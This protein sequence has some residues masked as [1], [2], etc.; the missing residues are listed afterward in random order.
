MREK[1]KR[2]LGKTL[3]IIT[4]FIHFTHPLI[5]SRSLRIAL[6]TFNALTVSLTLDTHAWALPAQN[7]IEDLKTYKLDEQTYREV[8]ND[9][10]AREILSQST[11][12]A[13]GVVQRVA[14][15]T[16][17][18]TT[19]FQHYYNGLEVIGSMSLHHAGAQGTAI[20]NHL[21]A[22][23]LSTHPSLSI[24]EAIAIAQGEAEDLKLNALPK[25]MILP[26]NEERA[27][28]LIYWISLQ[29]TQAVG[30]K[31]LLI[32]AHSGQ[33]LAEIPHHL[34]LAPIQIYSAKNQG[35]KVVRN[36]SNLRLQ[37]KKSLKSCDLINLE[38]NEKK[39]ITPAACFALYQGASP[40]LKNQC[41]V[42]DGESGDIVHVDPQN[43][44]QIFRDGVPQTSIEDMDASAQRAAAHSRVVLQYYKSHFNRD[45]Y[46]GRGSDLIS[47]THGGHKLANAMW[48]TDQNI[49]LYGDGDGQTMG[50]MTL[51]LDVAGHEM[52]HGITDQTAKLLMEGESGALNEAF[53]DFFGKLIEGKDTWVMGAD[54]FRH[55]PRL[56][57]GI[58]NLA[59]PDTLKDTLRDPKGRFVEKTYPLTRSEQARIKSGDTCSAE[60]DY[61]YVHYNSTIPSHAAYLV[62]KA[63]GVK[64]AELLYYT[65]LTQN[66]TATDNFTSSS[67]AIL[68]TC[69][70]LGFPESDCST[71]QSIFNRVGLL[72]SHYSAR[73]GGRF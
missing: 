11:N 42:L 38:T 21:S 68:Q 40:L 30:G 50:D 46:D 25:L 61:C 29:G 65:T 10:E 20:R 8:W 22:F 47:V 7:I 70:S 16:E 43:C 4:D 14:G 64:K 73:L 13:L 56:P 1:Y 12:H 51:A 53:S 59:Q 18:Y 44:M 37:K 60:N 48:I 2:F 15:P 17:I 58:R 24:E 57:Q 32:D 62:L 34:T 49:M 28:R 39:T 3:V 67:K 55:N 66:L 27:A 33:K 9:S 69:Q 54:L 45:S 63:I 19:K 5:S 26:M 23:D 31:D 71:I 52:T 36:Y 35:L 72:P 6:M 41:E